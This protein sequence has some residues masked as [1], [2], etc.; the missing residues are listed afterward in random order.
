MAKV[1]THAE[2]PTIFIPNE[3]AAETDCPNQIDEVCQLMDKSIAS[4]VQSM[5]N[6]LKKDTGVICDLID[7]K[8]AKDDQDGINNM[9]ARLNGV[10]YFWAGIMIPAIVI[11]IV[12]V[13]L[14]GK[15]KLEEILPANVVSI[16]LNVGGA[17]QWV[18]DIVPDDYT[19]YFV[20]GFI[21]FTMGT[22]WYSKY[23][24]KV[25][26]RLSSADKKQMKAT[27]KFLEGKSK[28]IGFL[29][30]SCSRTL[31]GRGG[32]STPSLFSRGGSLL[33]SINADVRSPDD[34]TAFCRGR[35]LPVRRPLQAVPRQCSWRRL[36]NVM[37]RTA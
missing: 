18:W 31:M 4:T 6:T 9:S 36:Q 26:K 23:V 3:D 25:T 30:R 24:W 16:V 13:Q 11:M 21:A 29:S 20:A 17:A 7:K 37:T 14:A 33:P 19:W 15:E 5:L 1:G 35:H 34:V 8:L 32:R 28:I 27:K 10:F 12:I 2:V 22:L